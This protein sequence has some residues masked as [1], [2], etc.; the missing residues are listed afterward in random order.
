MEFVPVRSFDSY[1]EANIL[2]GRLE[3]ENIV[4]TLKNE[5]SVTINPVLT[6]SVGGI[7]LC[8]A[9][10][11]LERCLELLKC[12]EV[13]SPTVCPDCKSTSTKQIN[14]QTTPTNLIERLLVFLL[15][16][17]ALPQKILEL[18]S[19]CGRV[20]EQTDRQ[21]LGSTATI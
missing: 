9:A 12:F 5:Y 4:C 15:G 2:M 1:I 7:Q 14:Q 18:C 13:K 21:I 20:C 16:P 19:A 8:V 3:D 10:V 17:T 6:N 11:Q